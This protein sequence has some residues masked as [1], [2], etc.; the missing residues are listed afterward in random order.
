MC[1]CLECFEIST[2]CY[3]QLWRRILF[4]TQ[5]SITNFTKK[6]I[7]TSCYKFSEGASCNNFSSYSFLL[8]S[9]CR[10]VDRFLLCHLSSVQDEFQYYSPL[11][12]LPPIIYSFVFFPLFF[13]VWMSHALTSYH[14]IISRAWLANF[15]RFPTDDCAH[16]INLAVMD[17]SY[18]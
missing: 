6:V 14:M 10:Y 16:N 3:Y 15:L 7:L 2:L 12:R 11:F 1:Q 8:I 17:S 13:C 9:K 4:E 18:S 5:K